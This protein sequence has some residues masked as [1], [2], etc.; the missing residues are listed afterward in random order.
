MT[1]TYIPSIYGPSA[2][3]VVLPCGFNQ[4]AY[5]LFE[6]IKNDPNQRRDRDKIVCHPI[7]VKVAQ[8]KAQD[9]LKRDYYSHVDPDGHGANW[10]VQQA[11]YR[12]PDAYGTGLTTNYIESITKNNPIAA[13]A[14]SAFMGSPNHRRHIMGET[15]HFRAQTNF[16]VGFAG[17]FPTSALYWCVLSAPY[18]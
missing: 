13:N 17:T 5:E 4:F 15:D 18:S 7:L 9:M 14:F 16:G 12:L 1:T 2:P 11:G 3:P 6:L 10:L 8:A